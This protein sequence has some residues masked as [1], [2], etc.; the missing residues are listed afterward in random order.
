MNHT[1]DLSANLRY[2]FSVANFLIGLTWIYHGIVPKIMFM[3]TGELEMLTASGLFK[4]FET[5]GVYAAGIAEVLF[6][7]AFW[8]LGK[9][10]ILHFLNIAS[11]VALGI[12]ACFAKPEIYLAPFNPATTSFGVIG[13]S[14]IVLRLL[15][16][17]PS[18]ANCKRK[19]ERK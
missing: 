14:V 18:A 7:L 11:L 5:E 19:P 2:I 1:P 12:I 17:I 16:F 6:G 4:G 15:K 8:L 3:E 10:R 13:L 9:F